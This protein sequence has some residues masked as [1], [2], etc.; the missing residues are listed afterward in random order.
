MTAGVGEGMTARVRNGLSVG[1]GALVV[2]HPIIA[3]V[4]S[5]LTRMIFRLGRRARGRRDALP[6]RPRCCKQPDTPPVAGNE[7]LFADPLRDLRAPTYVACGCVST[8]NEP[9]TTKVPLSRSPP[10]SRT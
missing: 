7:L 2:V 3:N 6:P 1:T 5:R 8:V 4:M 9:Q 10:P